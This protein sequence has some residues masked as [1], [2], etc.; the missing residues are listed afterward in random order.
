MPRHTG[1]LQPRRNW[2]TLASSVL[3]IHS[4]L[5]IWFH[6]LWTEKKIERSPFFVRR[7]GH[8]CLGDL[9]GRRNFWIFLS[10]LQKLEQWAKKCTERRGEYAE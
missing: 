3:I 1:N 8:C 6:L 10:D 2:P 7:R 9:V 4:I 5:R